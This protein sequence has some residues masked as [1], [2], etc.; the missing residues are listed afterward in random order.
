M[1]DACTGIHDNDV[2]QANSPTAL[3][4]CPT[5]AGRKIPQVNSTYMRD[6]PD[7]EWLSDLDAP[8]LRE[9]E[10]PPTQLDSLYSSSQAANPS[11]QHSLP[12]RDC[13]SV[14]ED[15]SQSKHTCSSSISTLMSKMSLSQP[16]ISYDASNSLRFDISS[17]IEP[18]DVTA[19][20]ILPGILPEYCWQHI[21]QNQLLRCNQWDDPQNYRTQCYLRSI[22]TCRTL[23]TSVF[24][25]II[26]R[27]VR[28]EDLHEVDAFGNSV[29]HISAT[30][31]APPSYLIALIKLGANI[32]VVNNAGETF[33]HLLK[34]EVLTHCD[35]LCYLFELL[36]IQGFNFRQ[37]DHLGQSPFHIL[38]RP[39]INQDTLRKIITQMDGLPIHRHISTARDCFGYTVVEQLNLC[40][41]DLGINVDHAILS[42]SCETNN[43]ISKSKGLQTRLAESSTKK[44]HSLDEESS[45]NYENHPHLTTVND[46]FL[47]EQHVDYWRTILTAKDSPWYEDSNGRNGL[48]CLAAASLVTPEKPL[49]ATLLSQLESLKDMGEGDK[50]SDRIS[51]IKSLINVGVDPN[52]HDNDGN[53]PFMAF[54]THH[55]STETDDCTTRILSCL[56]EA[57]SDIH[58][59]NRHG[60]TALHLSV[61]LGR[62]AATKYLLASGANIHAR[63]RSG[64][65]ILELGHKHSL[66]CKQ[67][68][69]LFAQ[70]M[71]CMSLVATCGAVSEPSIIDEWG[72]PGLR[73]VANKTVEPR[74]FKLVKK[75]IGIKVRRRRWGNRPGSSSK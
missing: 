34:P 36:R 52:N 6:N 3:Y 20:I 16:S 50:T 5:S 39:W 25:R 7:P 53:T 57:G 72:T 22:P 31:C 30:M 66:N 15:V 61:K 10:V 62:R 75:F 33:M 74:G 69:N 1:A 70:I 4:I 21:N 27:T 46:L 9:F 28:K 56:L 55:D 11:L 12:T 29:I 23:D 71:L 65:G 19:S 37:L 42:L 43:S 48:H 64:L 2:L 60:E 47:Y 8:N 41:T 17:G 40:G 45:R 26:Q 58:R 73:D 54:I 49:P 68:E 35:D 38:L 32:H 59:R 63:T 44:H 14:T 13:F 51:F 18:L 67:D 24:S